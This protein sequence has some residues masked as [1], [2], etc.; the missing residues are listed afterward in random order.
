MPSCSCRSAARSRR[1]A[2]AAPSNRTPTWTWRLV[3]G[4]AEMKYFH[5]TANCLCVAVVVAVVVVVPV[6]AADGAVDGAVVVGSAAA[7]DLLCRLQL[8]DCFWPGVEPDR[9]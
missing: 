4:S 7:R 9:V 8:V 5:E 3:L 6:A 1:S 2:P